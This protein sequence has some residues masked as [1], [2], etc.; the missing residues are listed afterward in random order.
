MR[1]FLDRLQCHNHLDRRA[2]GVGNDS[3]RGIDSVAGID[4]RYHQGH[5][6]IHAE[7][8]RIIDHQRSVLGNR[9]GKFFGSTCSR[10]YESDTHPFEIVVMGKLFHDYLLTAELVGSSGT[11]FRT[12]QQ[13]LPDGKFTLLQHP[14]ELLADGPACTNNRHFHMLS[15][16]MSGVPRRLLFH[17]LPMEYTRQI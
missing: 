3:P 15:E 17:A 11:T 8:T 14:Q 9:P 12:E 6:V 7:S 10:R 16:I 2:I 4:L 5:L 1:Q 13:Q